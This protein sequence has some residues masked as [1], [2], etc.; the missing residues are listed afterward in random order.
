MHICPT[1]SVKVYW[2]VKAYNIVI[3]FF[4]TFVAWKSCSARLFPLNILR[5]KYLDSAWNLGSMDNFYIPNI[6]IQPL[7]LLSYL[8]FFYYVHS[9]YKKLYDCIMPNEWF[10]LIFHVKVI[11]IINIPY[12]L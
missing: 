5:D 10:N 12:I 11:D 6:S 4:S 8:F 2:N 9:F 1:V 7:A 3:L